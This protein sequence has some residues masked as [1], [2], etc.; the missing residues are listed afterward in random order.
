MQAERGVLTYLSV[1]LLTTP[2]T[3]PPILPTLTRFEL[4]IGGI[5]GVQRRTAA[6]RG[7]QLLLQ[8]LK[9]TPPI[10]VAGSLL[11]PKGKLVVTS[12]DGSTD[13]LEPELG[14]RSRNL[15]CS[16]PVRHH[17]PYIALPFRGCTSLYY[18]YSGLNETVRVACLLVQ[19]GP[20][21]LIKDL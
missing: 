19:F 15:R 5:A 3:T 9:N 2:L 13:T 20:L 17:I 12:L 1:P 8:G 7:L 18:A 4:D 10:T 21:Y 6:I 16:A 11:L 14:N